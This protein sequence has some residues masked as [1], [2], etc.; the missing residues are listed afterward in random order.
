M[1]SKPDIILA[2]G[3]M[4][5]YKLAKFENLTPPDSHKVECSVETT[6]V[7]E[8]LFE[9]LAPCPGYAEDR[10]HRVLVP[11]KPTGQGRDE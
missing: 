4:V 3:T 6:D 5:D 10:A 11:G 2:N 9:A 7:A 1:N 8:G